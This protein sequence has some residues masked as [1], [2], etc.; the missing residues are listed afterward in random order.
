MQDASRRRNIVDIWCNCA[1]PRLQSHRKN[2]TLPN[3]YNYCGN[4][5]SNISMIVL[6]INL[7]YIYRYPILLQRLYAQKLD[8]RQMTLECKLT[9]VKGICIKPITLTIFLYRLFLVN[10]TC[11]TLT[12]G[13]WRHLGGR[14]CLS[15][16]CHCRAGY[17]LVLDFHIVA[18]I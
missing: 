8:L 3:L 5:V 18:N 11:I 10:F 15:L 7:I 14:V 6:S 12:L 13:N 9:S 2:L 17:E 1:T 16:A 4:I